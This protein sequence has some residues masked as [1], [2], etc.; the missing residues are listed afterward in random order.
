M[1]WLLFLSR[2]WQLQQQAESLQLPGARSQVERAAM[3][4]ALLGTSLPALLLIALGV[5]PGWALLSQ[6]LALSV[7]L[8]YLMLT[9]TFG[10][11]LLVAVGVLPMWLGKPLLVWLPAGQALHLGL[12]ALVVGFLA[13]GLSRW[14]VMLRWSGG[15]GW[16]APQVISMAERGLTGS[17]SQREDPTAHWVSGADASVPAA[18]GP[19]RRTLSLS[20]L[21]CGPLAPLG[22][23]NYLRGSVWMLLAVGFLGLLA[24]SAD[25]GRSGPRY[26]LITLLG[27]W[28]M[29]VPL[30]LITR[31]RQLWRD[32]GHALAEAALLPG[33]GG[34]G[35]GWWRLIAVLL[36]TTSY[37]LFLPALLISGLLL[38]QSGD[39]AALAVPLGVALWA[40]LLICALLPLAQRRS[41]WGGFLLYAGMALVLIGVLGALIAGGRLGAGLWFGLALLSALVLLLASAGWAWP[42]R[43]RALEQP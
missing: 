28:S 35:S 22:W 12:W 3:L 9:P 34:S 24:L 2:L 14:R 10:I 16:N 40:M 43:G 8:L 41:A 1:G 38:T 37:R 33:L 18:A 32:D 5:P 25:P 30:T 21:L 20:L 39:P 29:A 7:S 13:V 23:R 11:L 19:A 4:L 26:A 27:I 31:L 36:H 42:P 15:T 17:R 6:W